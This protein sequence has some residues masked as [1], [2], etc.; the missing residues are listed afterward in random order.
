MYSE[1][2]PHI[3]QNSKNFNFSLFLRTV[4]R[5]MYLSLFLYF[6]D[7][8]YYIFPLII[9]YICTYFISKLFFYT[10]CKN[11]LTWDVKKKRSISTRI[12][13]PAIV[14]AELI[15]FCLL[16]LHSGSLHYSLGYLFTN[17]KL[18]GNLA[19]RC[20]GGRRR[21]GETPSVLVA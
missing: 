2:N 9:K 18:I 1:Y 12:K 20:C 4:V 15:Y 21:A 14:Q 19:R 17:R 6:L 8:A 16:T 3:M 11:N 13:N 5:D 7:L 10:N